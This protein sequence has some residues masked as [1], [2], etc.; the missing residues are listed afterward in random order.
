MRRIPLTLALLWSLAG[1]VEGQ[2]GL[3][4]DEDGDTSTSPASD[5]GTGDGAE[6]TGCASWDNWACTPSATYCYASCGSLWWM[7][8]YPG[9]DTPCY[10]GGGGVDGTCDS[11]DAAAG[12]ECAACE[13]VLET[14]IRPRM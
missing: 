1:C 14:E 11:P 2:A 3:P 6:H 9:T 7:K 4:P 13:E 8:C 5:S 12:D 10:Y